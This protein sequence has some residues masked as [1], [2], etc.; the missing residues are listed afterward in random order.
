[1]VFDS[2]QD[3]DV[4]LDLVK[5]YAGPCGVAILG[6]CLMPN[7]V[8][9]IAT[10]CD[11]TGLA[12]AF[13]RAQCRY[14]HYLQAKRGTTGDLWQGRF[15][16]CVLGMDHLVRAMRYVKQ[17][18]ARSGLA[19]PAAEYSWSS[20]RAHVEGVDTRGLL[21]LRAWQRIGP[22][23][24]WH[25]IL[26]VAS[27]REDWFELNGRRTPARFTATRRSGGRSSCEPART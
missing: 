25:K 8:H 3:R 21:D 1:M 24:E 15:Y 17:N 2:D 12:A 7:H 4:D 18:P 23:E 11:E 5:A 6:Y 27:E 26:R 10:P 14:S 9:W 13:G 22:R 16:S 19:Q 20:A